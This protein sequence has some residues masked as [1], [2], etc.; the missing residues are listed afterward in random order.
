MSDL[1]QPQGSGVSRRTVTK[2]MAWAVPVIAVASPIPA[3]AASGNG[4]G[5]LVGP[6]CKIPGATNPQKCPGFEDKSYL[7]PFTFT[8]STNKNIYIL[9]VEITTDPNI[10]VG[11]AV[12]QPVLPALVPAQ[13]GNTPGTLE[14]LFGTTSTDSANVSFTAYITITWGHDANDNTHPPIGPIEVVV[15]STPPDCPCFK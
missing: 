9:D 12:A 11:F 4:P 15:G 7:F 13:V 3:F 2:A 5:Y 8:N 14:I 6:A 1:E 10:G